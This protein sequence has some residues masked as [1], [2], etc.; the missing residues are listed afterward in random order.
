MGRVGVGRVG[1]GLGG[2]VGRV[3]V[4]LGGAGR[5]G[6]DRFRPKGGDQNVGKK[7]RG[8]KRRST[9]KSKV[10]E[11]YTYLGGSL[12]SS[13]P[14]PE[15]VKLLHDCSTGAFNLLLLQ[16]MGTV[17]IDALIYIALK[18]RPI[19]RLRTI[20]TDPA[21]LREHFKTRS[22]AHTLCFGIKHSMSFAMQAKSSHHWKHT[23]IVRVCY[24]TVHFCWTVRLHTFTSSVC[25]CWCG[26]LACTAKHI[27]T[28]F[29]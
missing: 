13:L 9:E 3:G 21:K 23:E 14:Q 28:V 19:S 26:D 11:S 15:R 8:L 17:A 10:Y 29:S 6:I 4:G 2:R 16:D 1:V 22:A 20:T 7:Q 25:F 27:E 24:L 12:K 5:G 18:V